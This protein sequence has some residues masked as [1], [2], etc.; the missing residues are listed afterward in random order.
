MKNNKLVKLLCFLVIFMLVFTGCSKIDDLKVKSGY[1]NRDFDYIKQNKIQKIII[2]STR[3]KGFRFIVT[4]KRAINDLYTMLSSAKPVENKTAL[5]PDYVF[6]FHE[7]DEKVHKFNYVVGI[8][9]KGL[10]NFYDDNKAYVVSKRVD[11]DIIKNMSTLRKPRT[12]EE[13]YY[14]SILNFID[15]YVKNTQKD[16]KIGVNIQD[17]VEV[18][19]YMLSTDIEDFKINLK[20]KMSDLSLVEKNKEDFDVLINVKTYGYKT[21]VYKSI[22]TLYDKTD[23]SEL[24]YY[25]WCKRQDKDWEIN[26]TDQRPKDF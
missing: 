11:N 9:E 12:F 7:G 6:E 14:N 4:D 21:T 26:I 16:K 19:K 18:A 15:L 25:V 3:D 8:Q 17:D 20:N 1:K 5:P 23:N 2:Q 24:N 13:L 22:I 10:G